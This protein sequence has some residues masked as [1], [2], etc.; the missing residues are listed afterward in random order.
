MTITAALMAVT[1]P[2]LLHVLHEHTNPSP[3][4]ISRETVPGFLKPVAAFPPESLNLCHNSDE[5]IYLCD[6]S[7][8]FH[9]SS[10]PRSRLI[11]WSVKPIGRQ[12]CR[13]I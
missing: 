8:D 6:T 3:A 10:V 9:S 4:D 2:H 7:L 12:L 11:R 1:F 5:H 13:N